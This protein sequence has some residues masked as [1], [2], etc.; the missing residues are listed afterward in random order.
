MTERKISRREDILSGSLDRAALELLEV[1][2]DEVESLVGVEDIEES[3][4]ANGVRQVNLTLL[5]VGVVDGNRVKNLKSLL[6][7]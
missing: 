4:P 1:A 6:E 3:L 5:D 2:V 7:I